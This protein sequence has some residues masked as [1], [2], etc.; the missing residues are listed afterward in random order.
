M[1][2]GLAFHSYMDSSVAVV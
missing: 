1:V 2:L